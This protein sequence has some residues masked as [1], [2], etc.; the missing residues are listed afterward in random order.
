M[1]TKSVISTTS[2]IDKVP[3]KTKWNQR[4]AQFDLNKQLTIA[5]LLAT[6]LPKLP[7]QGMALD[8]A[9]GAG[10]HTLAL[11]RHGLTTYALDVAYQGLRLIQKQL[12]AN[13][14]IKP[15]VLDLEKGWLPLGNYKVILN[16]F[17]LER[18]IWPLISERLAPGGWF[19][20]ETF[21]VEQL[22]LP[23]KRSLLRKFMLEKGELKQ[24]FEK[25]LEILYY[26]EIIYGDKATAQL[27]AKKPL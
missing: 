26:N 25:S 11:A 22:N 20:M 27:I 3:A 23:H 24:V 1:R 12:E 2:L 4:Y 15:I 19:I 8:I 18:A 16:F 13:L 6:W 5:P 14:A 17:F 10:R 7:S 9:A 21:T